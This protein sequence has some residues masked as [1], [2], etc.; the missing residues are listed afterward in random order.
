MKKWFWGKPTVNVGK[1]GE[2]DALATSMAQ[3]GD[4]V[5]NTTT[6]R[7]EEGSTESKKDEKGNTKKTKT[8]MGDWI[9]EYDLFIDD[10]TLLGS[11][12]EGDL[13]TSGEETFETDGE[14]QLPDPYSFEVYGEEG[15]GVRVRKS[16]VTARPE[17]TSD[18]G[19][20]LHMKHIVTKPATGKKF[21]WF[22][23]GSGS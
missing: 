16:D 9:L 7:Q 22:K 14:I 5:E 21:K 17:Y 15:I 8:S 2:D 12:Y 20:V 23:V 19:A 1:T 10:L 11:V 6:F 18:G 13:S 3:F 4:I